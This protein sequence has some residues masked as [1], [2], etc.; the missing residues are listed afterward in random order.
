MINPETKTIVDKIISTMKKLEVFTI[1][2][3]ENEIATIPN[4]SLKAHCVEG[5]LNSFE[6]EQAFGTYYFN[7][8]HTEHMP[9]TDL[10]FQN[11]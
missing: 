8:I 5:V 6:I 11:N 2:Q 10:E 4:S 7:F 9:N 3:L 1:E